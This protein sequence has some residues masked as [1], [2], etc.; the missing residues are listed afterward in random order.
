[1]PSIKS[2]HLIRIQD[3]TNDEIY[4][5]LENAATFKEINERPI[6]KLPT[7]R[8]RTIINLF[9]EPST[10]TRSSFEL[11]EKR[12][13]ADSLNF[14]A[15]SSATVKGESLLDTAETF[16]AMKVDMVVARHKYG[17][18][19]NI[20]AD[21]MD[22]KIVNGGDGI[23]QHPTQTL[24]DLFTIYEHFGRIEGLTVGIVG[25]IYHSRVA[26]SLAPALASLGA[27]PIF[28]APPAYQP[29]VPEELGAQ[30]AYTLDEVLPELDVVNLLRIQGE[31]AQGLYVPSLREYSALYGMNS[32]RMNNLMKKDAIILHPGPM[33]RGV[34]VTAEVIAD[35][36]ML[37]LDQVN[38]GVA[39][40]MAVM[41]MMLGGDGDV[42]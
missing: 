8:G 1:M 25:D 15:S 33:N 10:R 31:R 40:R 24:L 41:Y 14:S 39:V 29:D 3:L 35:P 2:K 28:I 30:V 13:S 7:L 6:K 12:L 36:R 9:L 37:V 27:T 32:H 4:A 16:D 21:H 18:Y 20:L 17:G 42:E 26:G 19:C 5:V 23:H 34:E 38:A 22:A 11:A